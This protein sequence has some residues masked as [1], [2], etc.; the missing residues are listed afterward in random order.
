MTM[1]NM[2]FYMVPIKVKGLEQTVAIDR[3]VGLAS[4]SFLSYATI[5]EKRMTKQTSRNRSVEA[6]P[7]RAD[8]L[9]YAHM[10]LKLI[11]LESIR[12]NT[13]EETNHV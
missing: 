5:I 9:T 8:Q 13:C 4:S 11:L 6:A 12:C 2:H 1:D 7:P 10:S 3:T